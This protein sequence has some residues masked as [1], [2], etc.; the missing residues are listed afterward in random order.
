MN[1]CNDPK[2]VVFEGECEQQLECNPTQYLIEKDAP[3]VNED[4]EPGFQ[5][6]VCVKGLIQYTDCIANCSEEVCDGLDN[7]CDGEIDEGQLNACGL[8]GLVPP[9]ICDNI[10][11]DCDGLTDEDLVQACSTACEEDLEYC[12]AGG[13]L[14][15]AFRRNMMV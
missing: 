12:I 13:A 9:E 2:T 8:C 10:D 7:D 6:K 3:C 4:G 15:K 14:Q 1:E 11:N 5:D